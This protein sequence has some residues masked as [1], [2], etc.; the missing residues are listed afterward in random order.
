LKEQWSLNRR[1]ILAVGVL[2]PVAYT[3]V[4]YAMKL[5]PLSYVA[6]VRELSMLVGVFIGAWLLRERFAFSR[7]VGTALMVLG[8]ILLVRA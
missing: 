8:V 5:A 2:S 4:L 6:P 3:L 7:M 1:N